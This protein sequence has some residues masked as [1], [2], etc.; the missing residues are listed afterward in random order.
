MK[1][2]SK[3]EKELSAEALQTANAPQIDSGDGRHNNQ[4]LKIAWN[5]ITLLVRLGFRLIKSRCTWSFFIGAV[6]SFFIFSPDRFEFQNLGIGTSTIEHKGLEK[7]QQ[8]FQEQ[9]DYSYLEN[10]FLRITVVNNYERRIE[11]KTTLQVPSY[12][13]YACAVNEPDEGELCSSYWIEGESSKRFL[14]FNI[15]VGKTPDNAGKITFITEETSKK[16][17]GLSTND[18]SNPLTITILDKSQQTEGS[19]SINSRIDNSST[20]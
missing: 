16:L 19:N 6:L 8:R 5:F 1:N 17:L 10:E 12:I 3:P 2:V 4:D 14:Y 7:F 20:E 13:T 15:S 11:V 9:S 18:R